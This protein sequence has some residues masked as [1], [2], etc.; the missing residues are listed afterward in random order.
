M[1]N[2][3]LP[4]GEY[5]YFLELHNTW[6]KRCLHRPFSKNWLWPKLG[7]PIVVF[8]LLGIAKPEQHPSTSESHLLHGFMMWWWGDVS[9]HLS[10]G[11]MKETTFTCTCVFVSLSSIRER[12]VYSRPVNSNAV[13]HCLF[14]QA[15]NFF[16]N[17]LALF[18]FNR[19]VLVLIL[20]MGHCLQH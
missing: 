3:N 9:F 11:T 2:R 19:A 12:K 10:T 13:K 6:N 7:C 20:H 18:C 1:Q 17:G 16:V 8:L 4:W 14:C 15:S 5:G